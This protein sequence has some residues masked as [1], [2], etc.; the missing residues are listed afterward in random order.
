MKHTFQLTSL[1]CLTCSLQSNQVT[2]TSLLTF[3]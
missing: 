3:C 1:M 2:Y